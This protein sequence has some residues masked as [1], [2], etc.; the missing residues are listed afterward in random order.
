ACAWT[1]GNPMAADSSTPPER[2]V[3]SADGFFGYAADY[4]RSK[5]YGFSEGTGKLVHQA[6][7]ESANQILA[8]P[9][10][11]RDGLI[12]DAKSTFKRMVDAMIDS[13]KE[14]PGYA[15]KNPGKLGQQTWEGAK[16][17]L[18]PIWPIC[19]KRKDSGQ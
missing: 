4:A 3:V 13:S 18:C 7:Q 14:I 11:S 10:V 8:S 9:E 1:S 5:G 6:A 12:S 19:T 2:V 17:K 15:A 16:K